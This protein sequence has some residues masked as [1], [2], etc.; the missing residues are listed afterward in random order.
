ME[1]TI[2]GGVLF[3]E[4]GLDDLREMKVPGTNPPAPSRLSIVS[5]M[6]KGVLRENVS[7]GEGN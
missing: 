6:S 5:V 4:A 2:K 7:G 1:G 3:R